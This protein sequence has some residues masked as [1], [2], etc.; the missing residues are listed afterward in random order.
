MRFLYHLLIGPAL[1]A[2]W[3]FGASSQTVRACYSCSECSGVHRCGPNTSEFW[4]GLFIL[5]SLFAGRV[6]HYTQKSLR[7]KVPSFQDQPLYWLKNCAPYLM[8]V[9]FYV[10]AGMSISRCPE[11][12]G[13]TGCTVNSE[14][15]ILGLLCIPLSLICATCLGWK[16]ADSECQAFLPVLLAGYFCIVTLPSVFSLSDKFLA[17]TYPLL[18][19]SV[20][21]LFGLIFL[22]LC[23]RIP[24]P[25]FTHYQR[26]D[27]RL[28]L[29][30]V[31]P[32]SPLVVLL[33]YSLKSPWFGV[34]AVGWSVVLTAFSCAP[35]YLLLGFIHKWLPLKEWPAVIAFPLGVA[36]AYNLVGVACVLMA[37]ESGYH[38]SGLG[39][40]YIVGGTIS[41]LA[42]IFVRP[43]Q[44]AGPS[45]SGPALSREACNSAPA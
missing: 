17:E 18:P 28:A 23:S 41:T 26:P 6:A 16:L 13:V 39:P 3:V 37:K 36:T 7:G 42:P 2:L 31:L 25:W 32:A 33:I 4:F 12:L 9:P 24:S 38:P 20:V 43:S 29:A 21:A 22:L 27:N 44:P 8:E 19:V 15:Q 1:S 5:L 10:L 30:C 34:V 11:V 40:W 35:V 45:K 14:L